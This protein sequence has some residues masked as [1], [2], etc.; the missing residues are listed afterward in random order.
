MI[1]RWR[2]LFTLF[3]G[4]FLLTAHAQ[5]D[6]VKAA[7]YFWDTDPGPGNGTPMYSTNGSFT[8]AF[9]TIYQ[10]TDSLPAVGLHTLNIRAE[11]TAG[12][13][14]RVFTEVINVESSSTATR[15]D[16]VVAAEYFFDTDPGQGN[17]TPMLALEGNF[18]NAFQEILGGAIPAPVTSGIHLL[19][20]RAKDVACNWGNVFRVVVNIDT[21]ISAPSVQ[22]TGPAALCTND[23]A[24]VAYST[25]SGSG[26]T[27]SWALTGGIINSG[28]GTNSV[29]VTWN[30]TGP[31]QLKV[32]TCAGAICDSDSISLTVNPV[33]A[34][35]VNYTM[36]HGFV[37]DGYSTGGTFVDTFTASTGCDSIRTLNLTVLPVTDTAITQIIC[38]GQSFLGYN[39]T[40]NYIDTLTGHN[41]CDSIRTLNLTV[42]NIIQTTVSLNLCQGLWYRW[43]QY[44][45]NLCRYLYGYR[46]MRQPPNAESYHPR[47]KPKYHHTDYLP[48]LNVLRTFNHRHF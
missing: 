28:A 14:G 15:A 1:F 29:V 46:R 31:Y 25:P 23:L 32:T 39:Q 35:T 38:Q 20:M 9:A 26:Y 43:A 10:N 42:I 2:V 44:Q 11:D 16:G 12:N 48:G 30:S 45:W 3:F 22:I 47:C 34:T 5:Y 33:L 24:G 21:T 37:F 4:C 13:W 18:G 7:E 27:Y 8:Q 40:G 19:C 41:G 36:C 6:A 17:G